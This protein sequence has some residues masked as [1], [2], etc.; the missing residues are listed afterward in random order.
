VRKKSAGKEILAMERNKNT[1]RDGE[2]LER[3][4]NESFSAWV[5]LI[6]KLHE[7]ERVAC[8]LTY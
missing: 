2:V 6:P 5:L 7:Y 1:G 3:M 8:Q 4:F